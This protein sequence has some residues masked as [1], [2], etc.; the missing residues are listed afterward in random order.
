MEITLFAASDFHLGMTFSSYG[1]LGADL[2]RARLETLEGCV[3]TANREECRLFVIG[4]DLFKKQNFPAAL[5]DESAGILTG[6]AGECVCVLPGNHDYLSGKGSALWERFARA[7]DE[8]ILVLAE[9]KPYDLSSFGLNIVFYPGP[10]DARTSTDNRIGWIAGRTDEGSDPVTAASGADAA[11]H[12]PPWRIGIAH[13]SVEGL[14][15]DT[16]G[17]YFPMTLK[18][19]KGAGLDMWIVGHTHLK[20]PLQGGFLGEGGLL[21]PGTPEPDGFDC[22]HAGSAW[23]VSL[24]ADDGKRSIGIEPKTVGTYRFY[25]ETAEIRGED[26]I[27]E[28]EARLLAGEVNPDTSFLRIDFEGALAKDRFPLMEELKNRLEAAYAYVKL[29]ESRLSEIITPGDIEDEFTRGSFPHR[30]L[31]QLAEEE[32]PRALQCAYELLRKVRG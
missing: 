22:T 1:P 16:A 6:F 12:E 17:R 24:S 25:D 10:C 29:D 32:D 4:G 31:T 23:L 26:D 7:G 8:R 27:G 18:E 5:V 19:L 30:L 15:P 14:S 2:E 3:E 13:G 28:L 20:H 21:V 11:G 9:E